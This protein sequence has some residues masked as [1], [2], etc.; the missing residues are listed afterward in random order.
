MKTQ[1]SQC[2]VCGYYCAGKGGVGC[3]DKPNLPPA[4]SFKGTIAFDFDGVIH[5]YSKGWHDGTIY[6]EANP[7]VLNLMFELME[8][9]H[10]VF[11]LSTRSP[12]QIIRWMNTQTPWFGAMAYD[13]EGGF[14]VK[15]VP[16]WSKFWNDTKNLGVTNR[17]LAATHYIDDRAVLFDGDVEK[18]KKELK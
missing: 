2:P 17:K 5:K 13:L 14:E 9:G 6:D 4:N 15:K 12:K 18:L 16:F 7:L 1:E 11:I 3:I 8:A 10:P